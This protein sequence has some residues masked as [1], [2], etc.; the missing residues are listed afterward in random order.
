M[1]ECSETISSSPDT[2]HSTVKDIDTATA[3]VVVARVMGGGSCTTDVAVLAFIGACSL[4]T[5]LI[6]VWS[7]FKEFFAEFDMSRILVFQKIQYFSYIPLV[8]LNHL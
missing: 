3:A 1:T 6:S 5:D 4:V 2:C 8:I 7:Q